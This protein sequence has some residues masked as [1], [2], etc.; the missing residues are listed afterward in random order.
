[1]TEVPP[2]TWLYAPASRPE[3]VEKAI[4]SRAHA[5]IVDLEDAV[6]PGAK[7]EARRALPGLLGGRL[8][9]PVHV[10]VNRLDSPFGRADLEVAAALAGVTGIHLPKVEGPEDVL[11][12]LA[13]L[14]AV[15]RPLHCLIESAR[16]IESAYAIASS[17]RL[18]GGL[19]LGEADLG[20]E[21]GAEEDGL[22]WARSRTINA[23][24]AA[25]LQR[26]PQ[27]VY[28]RLRDDDGLARSCARGRALG[29]LGRT[30]IHP[31]QLPVIEAAYLPTERE[32][33]EARALLAQLARDPGAAVL[34]DGSFVDAAFR[35]RA[36]L[37][38][39]LGE[40]YG[41]AA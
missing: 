41:T 9:K 3:L 24:V 17:H 34:D 15:E 37:T 20:N 28:P 23:A 18:V 2:L 10:R 5:V 33:E 12:A 22:D 31:A 21:L 13:A 32:V 14:G 26:P 7:E 30:A 38:A 27:S 36:E 16:G 39:A 4:A 6:A 35:R 29:H 19:S 40:R 25:G 11:A 8:A 1:V